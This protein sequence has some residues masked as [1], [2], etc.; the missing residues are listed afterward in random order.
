MCFLYHLL[1][2][3]LPTHRISACSAKTTPKQDPATDDIRNLANHPVQCSNTN[4]ALNVGSN[5]S[6]YSTVLKHMILYIY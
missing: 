2:T 1:H 4:H 6:R 3:Y 5:D